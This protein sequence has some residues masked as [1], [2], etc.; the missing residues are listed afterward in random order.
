MTQ[1]EYSMIHGRSPGGRLREWTS[2]FTIE[3]E[4]RRQLAHL[5]SMIA[6]RSWIAARATATSRVDPSRS[7]GVGS[8]AGRGLSK[9]DVHLAEREGLRQIVL[10]AERGRH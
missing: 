6:S 9:D 7:G 3:W 10:G 5:C 2:L 1:I 8:E 4:E